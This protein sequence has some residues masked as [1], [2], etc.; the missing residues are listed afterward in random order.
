LDEKIERGDG[1]QNQCWKILY[2][3]LSFG[4]AIA[5][6]VGIALLY[7]FYGHCSLHQFFITF[8]FLLG[9]M[10]FI[11][12][13]IEKVGVGLL[14]PSVVFSYNVYLTWKAVFSN[15]DQ[16]CNPQTGSYDNAGMVAVG[17]V[18]TALSLTYTTWSTGV[19]AQN[20]FRKDKKPEE[21]EDDNAIELGVPA[22]ESPADGAAAGT[23]SA[24]PADHVESGK[25][26]KNHWFFHLILAAG[27][28]FMAMLLTNW[29]QTD[30]GDQETN[31]DVSIESMW[32]KIV[33]V[34]LTYGIFLWTV[35]AP[36]LFPDRDFGNN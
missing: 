5:G 4:L 14:V 24:N 21:V 33:C 19:T 11:I 22:K 2:L 10:T 7:H 29:G 34:W 12:C 26:F 32:V 18:I 3:C 31:T 20:L 35:I 28:I 16:E 13:V 8:T 25:R 9:I 6:V 23:V 15:P 17:L 27:A 1:E 36:F 30:G